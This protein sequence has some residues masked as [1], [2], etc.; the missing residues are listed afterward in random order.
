MAGMMAYTLTEDPEEESPVTGAWTMIKK[1]EFASLRVWC[2]MYVMYVPVFC[3]ATRLRSC[4]RLFCA[5]AA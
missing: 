5:F 2:V 3:L 1:R 4:F